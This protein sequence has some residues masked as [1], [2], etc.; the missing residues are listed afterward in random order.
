MILFGNAAMEEAAQTAAK[1]LVDR[2]P[3]HIA[4]VILQPGAA[5]PGEAHWAIASKPSIAPSTKEVA[6][7]I[8][9]G[10]ASWL[11]GSRAQALPR[12]K[13]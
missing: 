11:S 13:R 3:D 8:L 1:N 12:F 2:Y 6:G 9:R 7:A 5:P 4:V 10:L